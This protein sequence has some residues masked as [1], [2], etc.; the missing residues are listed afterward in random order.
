MADGSVI[1]TGGQPRAA[2]GPDLTQLFVG[3]EGT[4]GV[5]TE[6]TLRLVPLPRARRSLLAPV[7]DLGSGLALGQALGLNWR[8]CFF[9][10]LRGYNRVWSPPCIPVADG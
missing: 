3:A 5:V 10:R 8:L 1:R 9:V 4:L 7:G 6:V 2:V